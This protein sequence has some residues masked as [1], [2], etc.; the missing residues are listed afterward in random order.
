MAELV[1]AG[2]VD[3]AEGYEI[4][5]SAAALVINGKKQSAAVHERFRKFYE[6]LGGRK[7]DDKRTVTIVHDKD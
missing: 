7:L 2:L 4:K 1:K 5:L 6:E 3:E